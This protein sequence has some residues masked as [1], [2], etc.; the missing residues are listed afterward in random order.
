MTPKEIE[1]LAEDHWKYTAGALRVSAEK[2]ESEIQEL[3]YYYKSA[4]IHGFK[5][6]KSEGKK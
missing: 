1:Q 6:G 2:L 3:G 5:H 4:M